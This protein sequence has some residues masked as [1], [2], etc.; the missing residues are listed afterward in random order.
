MVKSMLFPVF[1]ICFGGILIQSMLFRVF[2][3]GMRI[4]MSLCGNDGKIN[5]VS[6][7]C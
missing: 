2:A 7:V 6:G 4:S 5:A 3:K 1:V